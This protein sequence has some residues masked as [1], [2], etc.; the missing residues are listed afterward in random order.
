MECISEINESLV[1]SWMRLLTPVVDLKSR[2]LR[3]EVLGMTMA[4]N[5]KRK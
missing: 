1:P 4:S 5:D 2:F 3:T